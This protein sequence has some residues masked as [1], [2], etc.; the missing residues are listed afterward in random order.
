MA[1]GW[2]LRYAIVIVSNQAIPGNMKDV[3]KREAYREKFVR[4]VPLIA[5]KVC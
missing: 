3:K 5:A 1:D 2:R 4:K